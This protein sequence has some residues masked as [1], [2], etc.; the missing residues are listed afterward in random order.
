MNFLDQN[1]FNYPTLIE[2]YSSNTITDEIANFSLNQFKAEFDT[3]LFLSSLIMDLVSKKVI[4]EDCEYAIHKLIQRFEVSKKIFTGYKTFI[5]GGIGSFKEIELYFMLICILNLYYL[6]TKSLSCLNCMLKLMD[7]L[8][9]LPI[10]KHKEI[11]SF[12]YLQIFIDLEEIF[13]SEL[14]NKLNIKL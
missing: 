7:L 9:S 14:M 13:I 5:K 3:F 4:S 2:T 1:S 8:I 10:E 11:N 6:K 12:Y